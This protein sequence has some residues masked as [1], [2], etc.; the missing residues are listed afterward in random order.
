MKMFA[1][2]RA[3]LYELYE[4]LSEHSGDIENSFYYSYIKNKKEKQ[5]EI[6]SGKRELFTEYAD[7]DKPNKF[8]L[9]HAAYLAFK[10]GDITADKYRDIFG[11]VS[12]GKKRTAEFLAADIM[13]ADDAK[14]HND[15]IEKYLLK[16]LVSDFFDN[17]GFKKGA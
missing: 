12:E 8:V 6:I 2:L 11:K 5:A 9:L 15:A 4:D 1:N 17:A 7:R 10:N 16:N 14:E 13:N 3:F